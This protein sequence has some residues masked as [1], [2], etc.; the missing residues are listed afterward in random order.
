MTLNPVSCCGLQI[1]EIPQ[2]RHHKFVE[3]FD[4]RA[5]EAALLALNKC[6]IAGKRIKVEPCGVRGAKFRYIFEILLFLSSQDELLL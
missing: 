5:A 2:Q 1:C 3:F 6:D 4:V